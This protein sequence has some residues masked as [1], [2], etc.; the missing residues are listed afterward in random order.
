MKKGLKKIFFGLFNNTMSKACRFFTALLCVFG[1]IVPLVI[2]AAIVLQDG[3]IIIPFSI[4]ITIGIGI[5]YKKY[6]YT[7]EEENT[8]EEDAAIAVVIDENNRKSLR[9]NAVLN[10]HRSSQSLDFT[11]NSSVKVDLSEALPSG[12]ESFVDDATGNTF[13]FNE[14]TSETT[15]E[16]PV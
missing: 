16:V 6:F 5:L 13:Y 15:W 12:W 11:N 7:T 14:E 10:K 9:A 4:L 2:F 8:F 1:L 3:T